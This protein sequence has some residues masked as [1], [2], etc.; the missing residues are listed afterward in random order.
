MDT[1]KIH[2]NRITSLAIKC[3]KINQKDLLRYWENTVVN[4]QSVKFKMYLPF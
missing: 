1:K 3:I 2:D 4:G